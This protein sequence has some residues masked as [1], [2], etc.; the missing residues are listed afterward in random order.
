MT[1]KMASGRFRLK[2]HELME[3][4]ADR[5]MINPHMVHLRAGVSYPPVNKYLKR[6]DDVDM[7]SLKVLAGIVVDALGI[8]PEEAL[9]KP[10]GFYFDYVSNDPNDDGHQN[11]AE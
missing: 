1:E 2:G 5:R 3:M 11:G 7:L 10:L 4:A 6:P 9:A 8:S